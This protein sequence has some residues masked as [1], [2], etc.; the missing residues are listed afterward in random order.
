MGKKL[1][2]AL[3]LWGLGLEVRKLRRG[4]WWGFGGCGVKR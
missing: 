3:A 1:S 4:G 2:E